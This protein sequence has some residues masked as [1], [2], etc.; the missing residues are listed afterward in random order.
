MAHWRP[1]LGRAAQAPPLELTPSGIHTCAEAYNKK[2]ATSV[3]TQKAGMSDESNLIIWRPKLLQRPETIEPR[4]QSNLPSGG[5]LPPQ[6]TMPL[7]RE[8][9][10][11]TL[12][13][14]GQAPYTGSPKCTA[15]GADSRDTLIVFIRPQRIFTGRGLTKVPTRRTGVNRVNIG[16]T[17]KIYKKARKDQG[18]KTQE[19]DNI[20]KFMQKGINLAGAFANTEELPDPPKNQQDK[21]AGPPL[22]TKGH[23][24]GPNLPRWANA[25]GVNLLPLPDTIKVYLRRHWGKDEVGELYEEAHTIKTVHPPMTTR[26]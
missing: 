25:S 15:D 19:G 17:H 13:G 20:P 16:S 6:D 10:I 7:G 26:A 12:K 4:A 18:T 1:P 23:P 5:A 3:D 9:Q 2:K 24:A 11:I 14:H 8:S 21:A 22:A